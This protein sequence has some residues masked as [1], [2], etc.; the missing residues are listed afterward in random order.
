[1]NRPYA[2]YGKKPRASKTSKRDILNGIPVFLHCSNADT[3]G[4]VVCYYDKPPFPRIC[5]GSGNTYWGARN[6]IEEFFSKN[7][8]EIEHTLKTLD[9]NFGVPKEFL[10]TAKKE[11][12]YEIIDDGSMRNGFKLITPFYNGDYIYLKVNSDAPHIN[13]SGKKVPDIDKILEEYLRR[14]NE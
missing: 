10:D 1:M 13:K 8:L 3:K 14:K 11:K 5:T 2:V 6:K 7:A 4:N 12:G 9:K